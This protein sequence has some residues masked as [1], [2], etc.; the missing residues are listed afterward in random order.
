MLVHIN[1]IVPEAKKNKYAVGAFNT[2]NL[3]TT[4]A[5]IRAAVAQRSPVIIQVSESTI[6]YAGIKPITHIVE[7]IA[8][9]EAVNVPVALHLDHGKSFHSIAECINSGFSSIMIDAS[10]L[11]FDENVF[12]TKSVVEYSHK[13]RAW[14]QGE[15][16][17]LKGVEDQISVKEREA[18]MTDPEEALEFEKQTDIDTLAVAVGQSHGIAKMRKGVPELN[19]KRLEKISKKV[20]SPLVLH[21]ASG[22]LESQIKKAI[23]LGVSI[24]N[25]DTEL[26]MA[27]AGSLREILVEKKEE[28]DPRKIMAP[29]ISEVQKTVENKIKM[30]GSNNK[31]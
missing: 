21:G 24:I 10:D 18:A 5:I 28:V 17:R 12:L 25:I 9:N 3:E 27:F 13:R 15:I 14:V 1:E 7:T 31:A 11:P 23:N 19:I 20:E 26:R 6:R 22:I 30:F 29:V 16:G 8:K 4:L 2:V